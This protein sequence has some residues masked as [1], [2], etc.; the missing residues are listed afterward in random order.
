MAEQPRHPDI[1]DAPDTDPGAPAAARP[2]R[3]AVLVVAVV[4]LVLALMIA[5]HVAG[6]VGASTNG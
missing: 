1:G 4:V 5:L 3:K 2:R 6:V